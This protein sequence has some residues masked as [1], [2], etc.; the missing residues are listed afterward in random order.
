MRS[1][2][3]PPFSPSDR[4]VIAVSTGFPSSVTP[5]PAA[6]SNVIR[7]AR[8]MKRPTVAGRRRGRTTWFEGLLPALFTPSLRNASPASGT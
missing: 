3:G 7:P 8:Y 5:A 4:S 2:S 6:G 1:R